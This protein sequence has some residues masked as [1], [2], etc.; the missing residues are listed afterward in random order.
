MVPYGFIASATDVDTFP[1]QHFT[2]SLVDPP[3]GASIDPTTG[4]FSWTPTAAQGPGTY[5]FFVR[6]SDG[7]ANTDAPITITVKDVNTAPSLSGVPVTATIDELVAYGF[8]ASAT[9]VDVPAQP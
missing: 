1:I 8:T 5:Q 7:F 3:V 4:A 6:V 2:F 9:D